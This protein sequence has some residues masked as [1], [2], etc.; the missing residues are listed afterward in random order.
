MRPIPIPDDLIPPWGVR[1]VIAPPDGDLL[2]DEIRPVE[3]IVG[4]MLQDDGTMGGIAFTMLIQ[5]E[6]DDILPM[7]M[8]GNRF[9]LTMQGHVVPFSMTTME[10][11]DTPE[12]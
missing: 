10:L 4:P 9:L 8:A 2:S 5:I 3:A 6:D 1:K 12:G 7:A 11:R